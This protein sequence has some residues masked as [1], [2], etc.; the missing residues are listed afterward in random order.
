MRIVSVL[1]MAALTLAERG[2][3]ESSA[4]SPM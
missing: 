4:I 1:L 3:S 2:A